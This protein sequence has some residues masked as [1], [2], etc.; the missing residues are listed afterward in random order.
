MCAALE[1]TSAA[2]VMALMRLVEVNVTLALHHRSL[3]QMHAVGWVK[4]QEFRLE[5]TM[6]LL[7]YVE[8]VEF[9]MKR[10]KDLLDFLQVSRM[11]VTVTVVHVICS[12]RCHCQLFVEILRACAD[13]LEQL[14]EEEEKLSAKALAASNDA[15]Q[16]YDQMMRYDEDLIRENSPIAP[17]AENK[18]AELSPFAF[19]ILTA[20]EH[21]CATAAEGD[22]YRGRREELQLGLMFICLVKL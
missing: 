19:T 21:F 13:R 14:D 8:C 17:V 20:L 7:G 5:L 10:Y 22:D 2:S 1:A 15:K 9:T 18:M 6:A 4:S 12:T 3:T 16:F 11:K